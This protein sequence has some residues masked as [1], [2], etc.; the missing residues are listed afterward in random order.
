MDE[1]E[2]KLTGSASEL[3]AETAIDDEDPGE[4]GSIESKYYIEKLLREAA[5][6]IP[7]P[8]PE[9]EEEEDVI[10]ETSIKMEVYDWIQCI[11]GTILFVVLAFMFIGRQIGVVG[12]SMLQT[13]HQEDK[14]IIS[15]FLY[16][17]DNGDVVI[18][19]TEEFGDTPIVKRV[20]AVGGQTIDINFDTHEVTVNGKVLYEPYIN[21]PTRNRE[22]F[23]GPV[24][25]P[26]GYVFCMGDNRNYST[27]SRDDRVGLIDT[28]DI[29]GKVYMVLIPAK[30]EFGIRDWAR[31]GSVYKYD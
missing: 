5:Y 9:P 29:L 31:I 21:E 8:E 12:D 26:E 2:L 14:L 19:K 7:E 16:T 24:T 22:N 28:R 13:L 10:P 25:V 27:D 23:A 4:Y 11:V 15:N 18:I 3:N 6:R 30:D 1:N 20:I 17:P